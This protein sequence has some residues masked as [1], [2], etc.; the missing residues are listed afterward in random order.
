MSLS[1]RRAFQASLDVSLIA[2]GC[3]GRTNSSSRLDKYLVTVA[4]FRQ[5]VT[6]V[7]AGWLPP[8]GS[9]KHAHLNG[10]LGLSNAV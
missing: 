10:G 7:R 6:A 2:A 4:L 3:G 8:A 9:G 5:F 1:I